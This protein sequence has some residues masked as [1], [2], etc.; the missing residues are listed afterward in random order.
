VIPGHDRDG[1]ELVA[2][3]LAVDDSGLSFEFAGTC[4]Y[5]ATFAYSG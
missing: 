1:E 2:E 5:S 4:G 3:E